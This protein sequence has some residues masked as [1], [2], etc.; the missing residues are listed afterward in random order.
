MA[1]APWAP[2]RLYE[3]AAAW[4]ETCLRNQRSLFGVA[5]A[6][7]SKAVVDEAVSR[8]VFDDTSDQDFITKLQTELHGLSDA[9][10]TFAAELLY[11]HVLPI[12]NMGVPAKRALV[13]QTLSWRREPFALPDDLAGALEGGV[14][15]YGAALTR[16]DKQVNLLA[17]FARAWAGLEPPERA[18][19]LSDPWAFRSFLVG[20]LELPPLMQRE[21]ILHL[22]FP[23]TFEY[24]LAAGDKTKIKNA[25]IELPRVAESE[26]DDRAVAAVRE[27]VEGAINRPLNLYS[28]WF[29]PIWRTPKAGRWTELVEWGRRFYESDVFDEEERDYKL[30][31]GER[32]QSARDA[33]ER[34]EA[35]WQIRLR[36]AFGSP[37]NMT[38]W[39][40][41]HGPFLEW[42]DEQ[43]ADA[44]AF[45]QALW[46]ADPRSAPELSDALGL[47]PPEVLRGPAA[48]LAVA[49]LLLAAHDIREFPPYRASVVSKF[50]D[51]AGA[52]AQAA[53]VELDEGLYTP[54]ELGALLEVDAKRIRDFLRA[55]FP[56]DEAAA[57]ERW[58][59][60]AEQAGAVV[61]HFS[62]GA[63]DPGSTYV[64]FLTLL[65]S[66]RI[67]LLAQGATLR[68]RLDA[69]SI[70]WMLVKREP[71]NDWSE[72]MKAA[73][74]RFRGGEPP[75]QTEGSGEL[76]EKAWLVRGKKANGFDEWFEQ[77]YVA[78]GWQELGELHPP[79]SGM[80]LYE[81]VREAY[82]EEPPGA[83]RATTGNLNSFLNRI[84]PGHLVLTADKDRLYIGRIAGD[85]YYDPTG[86]P[87][88]SRRRKVEW[89]N[90]NNPAS[91]AEVQTEYPTLYSRLR[92]LLTVTDLK[93]DVRTVAALA[94]LVE[95]PPEVTPPVLV[96]RVTDEVAQ[97]LFLPKDWLQ[98][99]LD[100][101][102]EK[103][104]VIFYGP[105]GTGKTF[106]ARALARH[107]TAEGGWTSI[108]Q[109]HPSFSYED[110]F[111]GYRPTA[112]GGAVEYELK[113]G[114]LRQAVEA[115]LEEP[116]RPAVLIVDEINRSDTAKVFGELLFLLEYRS[117]DVQLQ[118]SPEEPFSLPKN[119]FLIGTM[120]TADRS[121]ALVDAALRRRFYFIEFA[122][123]DEPVRSV[124]RKWLDKHELDLEPARLLD[125]LNERIARDE[126]AIGPSY[127]MTSDGSAPQLDRVWTHAILPVLEE[128]LYAS[129]RDVALDF[130]LEALRKA[131]APPSPAT[132]EGAGEGL[133]PDEATVTE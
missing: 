71:L 119:L 60:D 17:Q 5:D 50:V 125:T 36:E 13:D 49:A 110:F 3:V 19:L 58:E 82:P 26:N 8:M 101:L 28:P 12:S 9:A 112:A 11:V 35:D 87:S 90:A 61:A 59:L 113:H 55:E 70:A 56:R 121:I 1:R 114:P 109:F 21:A 91:R 41:E 31:V 97:E 106:V 38:H 7:W 79:P 127:L 20:D 23:D 42:C 74:E 99:I 43:P 86:L 64:E 39:Q 29:L 53:L 57:G 132:P 54:A 131:L 98:E 103:G 115:A 118:Y 105:P 107:L 129:G 46:A 100:L 27:A 15:N 44:R 88:A 81:R 24:S 84:Q 18:R 69:Q 83:W 116:E 32:L 66:L 25:F 51:L 85:A 104:Q 22:V 89:L 52:E 78:I 68:D 65:D 37:N 48:R 4:V 67:R 95:P 63:A 73:F 72:E 14:A 77:G 6:L 120:N 76:P 16:R 47:L 133:A 40:F 45:L 122:P 123:T 75:P 92:T 93:E 2:D 96:R 33:V 117:E 80:E 108:V 30:V 130:G 126:I 94:G 124:L 34:D 102:E 62:G 128:H 111:E 10:L